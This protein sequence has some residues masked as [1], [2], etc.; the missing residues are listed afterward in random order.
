M[1]SLAYILLPGTYSMMG[2]E[3]VWCAD[4]LELSDAARVLRK[5]A[6]PMCYFCQ[7][8]RP[9][10]QLKWVGRSNSR[11]HVIAYCCRKSDDNACAKGT[12]VQLS[13]EC[14]RIKRVLARRD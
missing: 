10:T 4:L 1:A 11:Y 5:K 6:P 8:P 2:A 13:K 9:R 12:A 14:D 3:R 7:C